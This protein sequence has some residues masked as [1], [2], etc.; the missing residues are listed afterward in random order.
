MENCN[1]KNVISKITI[2]IVSIIVIIGFVSGMI[3]QENNNIIGYIMTLFFG[4]IIIIVALKFLIEFSIKTSKNEHFFS[5]KKRILISS[6]VNILFSISTTAFI[7]HFIGN[8]NKPFALISS[9]ITLIL[10]LILIIVYFITDIKN[11]DDISLLK[12]TNYFLT[13]LLTAIKLLNIENINK[14]FF[15]EYYYILP[16]ILAQGLYELFDRKSKLKNDSEA[17]E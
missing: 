9:Q 12:A 16:I 15:I 3:L 1:P 13:F 17:Q 14:V 10:I 2:A 11:G 8:Y 5:C 4:S 7:V 6:A